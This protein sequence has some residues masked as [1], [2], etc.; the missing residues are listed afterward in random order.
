MP[1]IIT[2]ILN[3]KSEI[4]ML[5]AGLCILASVATVFSTGDF[6]FWKIAKFL[7]TVGVILIIFDR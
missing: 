4:T 6:I 5:A 2:N 7:Y 1:S 3:R